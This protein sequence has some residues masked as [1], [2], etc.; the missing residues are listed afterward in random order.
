MASEQR[1][2][3]SP[4][5]AQGAAYRH[6]FSAPR[7]RKEDAVEFSD[8]VSIPGAQEFTV[9]VRDEYRTAALEAVHL[10]R[11]VELLDGV[12]QLPRIMPVEFPDERS[13]R[14]R[15]QVAKC[16]SDGHGSEPMTFWGPTADQ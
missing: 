2:G 7:D 16:E 10:V 14:S 9:D 8:A 3:A 15:P 5:V 11:L 13:T 1:S 6:E 12:Q 4:G